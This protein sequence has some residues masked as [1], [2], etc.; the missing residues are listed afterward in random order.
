MKRLRQYSKQLQQQEAS[1]QRVLWYAEEKVRGVHAVAALV[2]DLKLSQ[3][4][5]NKPM[6][7]AESQVDQLELFV[8]VSHS[9][10]KLP[11]F[12]HVYFPCLPSA[13]NNLLPDVM[14]GAGV[15]LLSELTDI[16][17]FFI[18]RE[19][20]QCYSNISGKLFVIFELF[21]ILND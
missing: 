16:I 14:T 13:E 11:Y 20:S 1:A 19:V 7:K 12:I 15:S 2:H 21:V 6:E 3:L 10:F 8:Q 5:T 4:C 17:L 9:L 18:F